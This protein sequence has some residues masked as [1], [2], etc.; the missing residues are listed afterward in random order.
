MDCKLSSQSSGISLADISVSNISDTELEDEDTVLGSNGSQKSYNAA[1]PSHPRESRNERQN[2]GCF[3]HPGISRNGQ[4]LPVQSLA[5]EFDRKIEKNSHQMPLGDVKFALQEN[6]ELLNDHALLKE[7]LQSIDRKLASNSESIQTSTVFRPESPLMSYGPPNK[8]PG[9]GRAAAA[10]SVSPLDREPVSRQVLTSREHLFNLTDAPS[11]EASN[12]LP[13]DMKM[14]NKHVTFNKAESNCRVQESSNSEALSVKMSR[15]NELLKQL[16]DLRWRLTGWEEIGVDPPTDQSSALAFCHKLLHR[17][18]TTLEQKRLIEEQLVS[19]ERKLKKSC[20]EAA[21]MSRLN[22]KR[23]ARMREADAQIAEI[24]HEWVSTRAA[25]RNEV[26][27]LQEECNKLR[28]EKESLAEDVLE[29]G[30]KI[31]SYK[32]MHKDYLKVK[33][34]LE[35][36][37]AQVGT[38]RRQAEEIAEENLRLSKKLEEKQ[39]YL[40]EVEEVTLNNLKY[41]LDNANSRL[42]VL[43]KSNEK[44]MRTNTHLTEDLRMLHDQHK[45]LVQKVIV[46][47]EL[48]EASAKEREA[49]TEQVKSLTS[50]MSS[51]KTE[52]HNYYQSQVKELVGQKTETLQE[53]LMSLEFTLKDNLNEH[54][55]A[56]REAHR[57]ALTKIQEGHNKEVQDLCDAHSTR[58][59]SLQKQI[60]QLQEENQA[61]KVKHQSIIASVSSILTSQGETQNNQALNQM[62]EFP[63]MASTSTPINTRP[64]SPQSNKFAKG[65]ATARN[66]SRPTSGKSGHN[67]ARVPCLGHIGSSSSDS[68]ISVFQEGSVTVRNAA[69]RLQPYCNEKLETNG[70]NL[71]VESSQMKGNH[72]FKVNIGEYEYRSLPDLQRRLDPTEKE[73][74]DARKQFKSKDPIASAQKSGSFSGRDMPRPALGKIFRAS[75]ILR[76]DDDAAGEFSNLMVPV[77]LEMG[78]LIQ[79]F[80]SMRSS[81]KTSESDVPT[82]DTSFDQDPANITLRKLNQ[83]S[84]LLSRY[85]N[86]APSSS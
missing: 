18:Q 77:D 82:H 80:K 43:E 5:P 29:M 19:V 59:T 7:L 58:V 48:K 6:H 36:A 65:R 35:E 24:Q 33:N 49:L 23:Q 42:A 71:N 30:K 78:R 25:N 3:A 22:E 8:D 60:Q 32:E 81:S 83:V 45:T 15:S 51:T 74:V 10:R 75:E 11:N 9:P 20:E 57:L 61:L 40:Q 31:S 41:D 69:E 44:L 62:L 50:K 37:V 2:F 28:K 14:L 47:E 79:E 56:Q 54:L 27:R 16:S 67:N 13:V 64:V 55:E 84:T 1:E 26:M 4:R 38:S 53:Q 21:V 52:L 39:K 34:S 68:D 85:V 72:P 46:E 17:L 70:K 73:H 66:G 76:N 86:D 12:R 63:N